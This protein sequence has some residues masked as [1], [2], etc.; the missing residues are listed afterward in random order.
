MQYESLKTLI[1][2][3]VVPSAVLDLFT[4]NFKEKMLSEDINSLALAR[5]L[6]FVDL[7]RVT[8]GQ[9]EIFFKVSLGGR[10]SPGIMFDL[11]GMT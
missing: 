3:P 4:L 2:L 6:P 7:E 5:F 11:Q 1:A 9:R 10:A 8:T